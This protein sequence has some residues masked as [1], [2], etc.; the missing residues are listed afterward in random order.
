VVFKV[1][2]TLL[3][4]VAL[5]SLDGSAAWGLDLG[6]GVQVV[7]LRTQGV[8]G[9]YDTVVVERDG[10]QAVIAPTQDWPDM[11]TEVWLRSAAQGH[12]V[13]VTWVMNCS[14][15]VKQRFEKKVLLAMVEHA[16]GL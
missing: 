1:M 13:D 15:K 7:R 3:V 6:D 11:V 9:P 5:V 10:V 4:L 2:T 14:P 12:A 8:D 16:T